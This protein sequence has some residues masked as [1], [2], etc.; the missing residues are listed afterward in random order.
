MNKLSDSVD[1]GDSDQE[2]DPGLLLDEWIGELNNLSGVSLNRIHSFARLIFFH[3][4]LCFV[5]IQD[6]CRLNSL[7]SSD[8]RN[9]LRLEINENFANNANTG[10]CTENFINIKENRYHTKP[11]SVL[12]H[13]IK[14]YTGI[15]HNT[16]P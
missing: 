2:G 12:F 1:D 7:N 5:F 14:I 10:E 6:F 8:N 16:K 15:S 4:S 13:L 11:Q 9:R 3:R